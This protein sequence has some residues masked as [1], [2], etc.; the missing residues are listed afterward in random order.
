MNALTLAQ[1][2]DTVTVVYLWT[3]FVVWFTFLVVGFRD[4]R[5]HHPWIV[6]YRVALA[7]WPLLCIAGRAS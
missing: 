5:G 6:S 3:M 2:V 4:E 7:V 1:I